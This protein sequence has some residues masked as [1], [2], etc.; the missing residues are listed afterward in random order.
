ML[1]PEQRQKLIDRLR[2]IENANDGQIAISEGAR[3]LREELA[4][5]PEGD[6]QACFENIVEFYTKSRE[7]RDSEASPEI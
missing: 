6:G 7:S 1:S 5:T 3:K 2:D 4:K